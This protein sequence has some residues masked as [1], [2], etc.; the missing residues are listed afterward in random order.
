VTTPISKHLLGSLAA[1]ALTAGLTV[2]LSAAPTAA[3]GADQPSAALGHCQAEK[4]AAA[5]A[6]RVV[7][8]KERQLAKAR[9]AVHAAQFALDRA[10]TP[11]QM[12]LARERL[13]AAKSQKAHAKVALKRAEAK[14]LAAFRAYE[15]CFAGH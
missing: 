2:G 11:R 6:S 9:N 8:K 3:V 14:Q 4:E 5:H 12:R 7:H 15:E 13:A 1:L 10:S